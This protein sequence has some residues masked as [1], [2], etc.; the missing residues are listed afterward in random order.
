MSLARVLGIFDKILTGEG[1]KLGAKVQP[2][3]NPRART[4]KVIS[5]GRALYSL[6][7]T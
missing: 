2:T 3:R 1:F 6:S 7:R 4:C 5:E